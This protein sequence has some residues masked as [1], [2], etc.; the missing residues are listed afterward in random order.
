VYFFRIIYPYKKNVY[1]S[2]YTGIIETE[3]NRAGEF[4]K[5]HFLLRNV[6]STEKEKNWYLTIAGTNIEIETKK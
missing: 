4:Y 3:L 1:A 6:D 2:P 5:V